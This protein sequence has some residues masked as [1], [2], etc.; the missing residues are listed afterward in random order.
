[1]ATSETEIRSRTRASLN[2]WKRIGINGIAR[3]REREKTTI[4]RKK[5]RRRDEKEKGQGSKGYGRN[6]IETNRMRERGEVKMRKR[7]K[8]GSAQR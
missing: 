8:V 2:P 1:M 7:E 6:T 4:P 3:E 5:E